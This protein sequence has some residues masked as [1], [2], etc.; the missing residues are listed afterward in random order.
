MTNTGLNGFNLQE[1]NKRIYEI[2]PGCFIVVLSDSKKGLMESYFSKSILRDCVSN[3]AMEQNVIY[4]YNLSDQ[5]SVEVNDSESDRAKKMKKGYYNLHHFGGA[6][7]YCQLGNVFYFVG[8]VKD[9]NVAIW[10]FCIKWICSLGIGKNQ[11]HLKATGIEY[12]GNRILLI[13][14][15]GAGKSTF[16]Y[17]LS[18]RLLGPIGLVANTHVLIADDL[19]GRGVYSS[20]N[21]RKSVAEKIQEERNILKNK[22]ITGCTNIDP[23]ELG[24]KR[25]E[26]CKFNKVI[27]YQHNT[28]G[29]YNMQKISGR[30]MKQLILLYAYGIQFYSLK[31]DLMELHEGDLGKVVRKADMDEGV[32]QKM[33]EECENYTLSFDAY[34][35]DNWDNLLIDLMEEEK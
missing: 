13:G 20:I 6:I 31:T 35:E 33:V 30:E 22:A 10:S 28:I 15:K 7:E 24:Y 25:I 11:L 16:V 21:F 18:K 23:V 14:D 8:Y 5:Y 26:S 12:K 19:E 34:S 27:F 3:N 2:L 32:I 1:L 9:C 29:K 17:E 4:I